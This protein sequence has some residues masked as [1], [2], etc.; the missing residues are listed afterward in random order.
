MFTKIA[1]IV[2]NLST[3]L[4]AMVQWKSESVAFLDERRAVVPS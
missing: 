1:N 3:E 2:F 4:P